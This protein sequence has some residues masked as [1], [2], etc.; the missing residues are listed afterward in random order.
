MAMTVLGFGGVFAAFTYIAPMMTEVAGFVGRLGHLAARPLRARHG[1]RQ[2]ARRQARRP[3]ADADACT[4]SSAPS[5]WSWP[6]SRSPRTTRSRPRSPS[7][8]SAP[9][10]FATVAP[11]Q[12]RVMD[13][14]AGAPTLASAA[15]I[16]AFNLGNAAR[17]LAR[18]PR[19]RSRPRLHRAQLGRRRTRRLRPGPRPPLRRSWTAGVPPLLS[20]LCCLKQSDL[21]LDA[22]PGGTPACRSHSTPVSAS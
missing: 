22:V 21:D 4:S 17:R 13:Q 8:C 2:P 9:L 20:Q 18:R 15:N 7:R 14:A 10:G 5:P 3:G 19:H 16:G 6:C 12:K 1:R 11:L